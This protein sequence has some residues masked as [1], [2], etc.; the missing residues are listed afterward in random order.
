MRHK[1][2]IELFIHLLMIAT[3]GVVVD[4]QTPDGKNLIEWQAGQKLNWSD[5]KA[6]SKPDPGFGVATT[7][8]DFLYKIFKQKG[9]EFLEI[10]V[11]FYCDSSWKN[12]NFE[13]ADILHHEQLHFDI[14]ELFARKFCKQVENLNKAGSVTRDKIESVYDSLQEACNDY[15]DL[16]DLETGGSTNVK[17]Q[18]VWNKKIPEELNALEAYSDYKNILLHLE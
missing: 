11:V 17:M 7:T 9:R 18:Q 6:L 14:N 8:S 5:F 10:S 12:P 2:R 4:A 16:Y 1:F 13:H 3:L 15:Q